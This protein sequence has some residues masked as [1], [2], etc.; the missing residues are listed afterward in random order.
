MAESSACR[1]NK[2]SGIVCL[3][4]CV[5]E[6]EGDREKHEGKKEGMYERKENMTTKLKGGYE[7]RVKGK[8]R[9][10]AGIAKEVESHHIHG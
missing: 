4:V 6:K 10:E 7:G 2:A 9:S 1:E 8:E 3:N 5:R